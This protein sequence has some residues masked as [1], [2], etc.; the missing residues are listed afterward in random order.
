MP[1]SNARL[2]DGTDP[3]GVVADTAVAAILHLHQFGQ[4]FRREAALIDHRAARIGHRDN[5][6]PHRHRL[7][8]RVLGNVAGTRNADAQA[9]EAAP[10]LLEHLLGEIDGAVAGRFRADQRTA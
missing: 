9:V 8:D 2:E 7:F 1:G 6:G 5:L 10:L 3:L 4:L